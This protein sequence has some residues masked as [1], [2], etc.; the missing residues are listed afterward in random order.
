MADVAREAGVSVMTV[1][2]AYSNPERVA[3]T[4]RERVAESARH[5]GYRGP[6]PSARSL[7]Q[8]RSNN[9]AVVVGEGLPYAFEDQQSSRFLAGV[10]AVCVEHQQNLMLLP[11]NGDDT[12]AGRIQEAAADAFILWTGVSDG[13]VLDAILATGKPVAIQGAPPDSLRGAR[14]GAARHAD[15]AHVVTIDDRAAAAAVAAVTFARAA[16][17]SVVSFALRANEEP[18]ILLGPRIDEVAF[19]GARQR[20]RGIRDACRTLGIAWETVPVAVVS[21]NHRQDARPIVEELF[22][23]SPRPDA[24][25]AMS[26]QLALAVTDVVAA[27]GLRV[28]QNVVVSGWDDSL[29]AEQA[30]L[31]S[32]H[33]SLQDQGT[34]CAMLALGQRKRVAKPPWSLAVRASTDRLAE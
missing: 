32:V 11:V 28:P 13:P 19:P 31:T 24:V 9:L 10:A 30:G 6:N 22:D 27:S 3:A 29:E 17:P 12:D 20:L 1:S 5:L 16:T 4:T 8:G 26:D 21:R 34:Q 25:V 33:Q 2:Y 15:G 14:T 23:R 7:R 18:A